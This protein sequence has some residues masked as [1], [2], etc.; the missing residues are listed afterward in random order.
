MPTAESKRTPVRRPRDRKERIAAAASRLFRERGFHN[1]SVAD[2]ADAVE[3]TAPALYRHFRNKR[4]LLTYVVREGVGR[5][6]ELAR[7][8][9]DLDMLLSAMSAAVSEDRGLVTLW[10]REARHLPDESRA[11]LRRYLTSVVGRYAALISAERPGLSDAD[12]ELLAWA[13]LGV[14]GSLTAT[15][16]AVSRTRAASTLQHLAAAV[17]RCELDTVEGGQAAHPPSPTATGSDQVVTASRREQLLTAAVRLFDERGFQSVSTE[18]IGEEAGVS[19]PSIYKHFP[20]KT[21]ILVAA[22]TRAGERRQLGTDRAMARAADPGEALDL[23]LRSYIDF[24]LENS[25]LMGLLISELDQL[26]DANRR[27]SLQVQRDYLALWEKVLDQ[28]VPGVDGMESKVRVRAALTVVD[29][30]AR[31][32]RLVARAD[33]DD[34]LFEIGQALLRDR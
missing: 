7:T 14:F 13:V 33:I 31:T 9:S 17:A 4:E 21:D 32:A 6:D 26:P 8:A 19:G 25:H 30:V 18:D 10:Q 34:R 22:V 27:R 5:L 28:A 23:L 15:R 24:A 20:S 1:V 16:V 29:N 3:I 11:E 12:G 2:I